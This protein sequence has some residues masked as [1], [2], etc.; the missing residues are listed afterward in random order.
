ML[1]RF[2]SFLLGILFLLGGFLF[3]K[4]PP[5]GENIEVISGINFILLST[6]FFLFSFT[7]EKNIRLMFQKIMNKKLKSKR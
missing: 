2:L 5:S 7:G 3:I 4:N 1:I 6:Y